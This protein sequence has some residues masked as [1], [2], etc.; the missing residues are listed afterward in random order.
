MP[1]DL[2]MLQEALSDRY[3][4]EREVGS[5]RMAVVYLGTDRRH[6]R[7]V[8]IKVLRPDVA[9]SLGARRFLREIDIAAH[10]THPHIL[11]LHD[12]GEAAGYLYYV[13]PY[14]E[15][16]TLRERLDRERML[17]VEEACQIAVEVGDA[18]EYAHGQGVIHRDIKPENILLSGGHAVVADFGLARALEESGG[19]RLTQTGI[20]IGAPVYSSPEQSGADGPVDGR[21]DQ[22]SLATVIYEMLTGEPPFAGASIRAIMA[23][24]STET[25]SSPRLLRDSIPPRVEA[26]V[27]KALAKL[28]A[29]R[30][31]TTGEFCAALTGGQ[32]IATADAG[33]GSGK[34]PSFWGELKRRHV[35]HTAAVYAAVAWVLVEV[36]ATTFPYLNIPGSAVTFLIALAILGFPIALVLAWAYEITRDGIRRT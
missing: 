31:R 6:D 29:D 24:K 26:A 12:S 8:A 11:G 10:L 4:I 28:P 23:R 35:Y 22:Y 9:A 18:L 7:Q 36:S 14:I 25:P 17:P 27:M 32:S 3:T 34:P 16:E 33:A 1:I 13:M 30:Y 20:V 5:G 21:T 2:D 19:E 15:G